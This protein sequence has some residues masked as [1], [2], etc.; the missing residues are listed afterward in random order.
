MIINHP[1][2]HPL[3][4]DKDHFIILVTGGRGSGKSY[5]VSTFTERLTFEM[6]KILNEEGRYDKLV[7]NIL[8]TRYTMASAEISV[9][10][11]FM[12]K[13]EADGTENFFHSTK[14]DI[15]N[16]STKSRIMFRGIRTSSGNQTAKLKSIHG[17]TTFICDEAEEW[18]SD[19]EFETIMFSIRQPGIQNRVIIIMNPTDSNHFIYQKYIK[20]THKIEY[21]DGVP[22][23]ISTHPNVL[24]IHTTYLDNIENLSDEFIKAAQE[25]KEKNPERYAHIFMGQ[26]VDVAEGAVFKKWG[27]VEEIP[28]YAK[29]LACGLDFGYTH[30]P[31]ACIKAGIVGNDLY[32]DEM[33]YRTGMGIKELITELRNIGLHVYADSAD[34][35]LID[36]ISHGGVIIYPVAK[37]AG[38]IIAGIEKMKSFD[39]IF[40]TKRSVNLQNELRNYVWAKDKNGNFINEPEDHD[41]HCFTG[42]TLIT[43]KS[44]LIPIKDVTTND[45]VLTSNG[46]KQVEKVFNNGCKKI[47]HVRLNFGNFDIVISATPEHKIKTSNGWKQLQE[48]IAGDELYL[49]KPLMGKNITSIQTQDT[50]QKPI[51]NYI[52]MYGNITKVKSPKVIMCI[53]KTIIP[54]TIRLKILNWWNRLNIFQNMQKK[55]ETILK[56]LNRCKQI[57]IRQGYMQMN[58]IVQKKAEN[59]IGNMGLKWLKRFNPLNLFANAVGNHLCTSQVAQINFAPINAN[60]NI[61]YSQAL[62]MKQ[63]Y[64]NIAEKNLLSTSITKKDIVVGDVQSLTIQLQKVQEIE[65]LKVDSANVFDLQV[66]DIHEY[67]AN[68]ILVHNCVD[69]SRY[70]LYGHILGQIVKPRNVNKSQLGIF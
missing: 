23:Q 19:R 55:T 12:E 25:M 46:Y 70:Y 51:G 9:I 16:L 22:V 59:G 30:D 4:F 31:S 56:C 49:F 20:D 13:V 37:P 21:F 52:E 34:P 39:N 65:I 58:G 5:G 60:Q 15:I 64:A 53:T 38:S 44:G 6:K 66:K 24:H 27:I 43:C 1:V 48:L 18:T 26:W 36:E 7:H 3:Y 32:L 67:F 54:T 17:I 42:D 47:L 2:Y 45:L 35:R 41:N 62:T 40:V 29:K 28:A 63:E 57:W 11:E 10:P 14:K 61:G 68:G 33:F 8:Y 50:L 69:A